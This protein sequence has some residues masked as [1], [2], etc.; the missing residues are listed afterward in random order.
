MKTTNRGLY[1]LFKKYIK[2]LFHLFKISNVHECIIIIIF[3][4]FI[5]YIATIKPEAQMIYFTGIVMYY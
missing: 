1:Q 2:I 3:Y 4:S 5:L